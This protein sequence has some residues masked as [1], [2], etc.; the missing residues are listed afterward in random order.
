[1]EAPLKTILSRIGL[2]LVITVPVF[3]QANAVYCFG[4]NPFFCQ[5][6]EDESLEAGTTYWAYSAGS[7]P[8]SVTDQCGWGTPPPSTNAADLDPGDSVFQTVDTDDFPAWSVELDV[9]KT[10]TSV[11]A[12]D[13]FKV[14]VYNY[15]TFQSETHYIYASDISGLCG[16]NISIPLVNDHANSTVRVRVEKNFQATATMYVDDISLWGGPF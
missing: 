9:Y 12:N 13:Y 3:G 5:Y 16:S 6:L 7:G 10:S 14:N 4:S 15:T 8:A 2:V 11:T 1:M